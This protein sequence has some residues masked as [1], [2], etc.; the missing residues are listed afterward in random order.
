MQTLQVSKVSCIQPKLILQDR[1]THTLQ[2]PNKQLV[3]TNT[4]PKWTSWGN[5]KIRYYLYYQDYPSA[6]LGNVNI[7][8]WRKNPNSN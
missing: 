1:R 5:V 8:V 2:D 3:M 4:R 6:F 7:C